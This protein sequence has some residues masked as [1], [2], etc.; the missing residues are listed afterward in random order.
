[1][2][3][4]FAYTNYNVWADFDN[5]G[6]PDLALAHQ[7]G[8]SSKGKVYQNDGG[9]FTLLPE[10]EA[11]AISTT[12]VVLAQAAGTADF[13]AD[14]DVDIY[15]ANTTSQAAPAPNFL[16]RNETGSQNNWLKVKLK[17]TASSRSGYGS[18]VFVTAVIGGDTVRQMRYVTGGTASYSFQSTT[19]QHFGLGDAEE[20]VAVEVQWL[21]GALDRCTG[22][23]VNQQVEIEEG[24]CLVS[25]VGRLRRKMMASKGWC[26]LPTRVE[27]F[28]RAACLQQKLCRYI[29]GYPV[30]PGRLFSRGK[31]NSKRART[32]LISIPQLFPPAVMWWNSGPDGIGWPGVG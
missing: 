24:S 14:G 12:F 28:C 31:P 11:G 10:A 15:V 13:D 6:D 18:K 17:G 9:D 23:G 3:D 20:V 26:F 21:S 25:G 29:G 27:V 5:D 4:V 7:Q 19:V 1:M 2:L 22:V 16:F 8:G 32:R 30:K